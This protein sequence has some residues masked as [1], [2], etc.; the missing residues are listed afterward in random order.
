MQKDYKSFTIVDFATDDA[1]LQHHLNPTRDSQSF[2]ENWLARNPSQVEEWQQAQKLLEAVRLGLEDYTRTFL[3]KEAEEQLLNRILNTNALYSHGSTGSPAIVSATWGKIFAVA[4]CLLIMLSIGANY[5]YGKKT[6]DSRTIYNRHK[7]LLFSSVIEKANTT[8]QVDSIKL[9]DGS[10]VLL[11]PGS[12][13]SYSTEF[14]KTNRTVSIS[15]RT[16]LDVVKNPEK[17]FIV[18]ANE[19]VTRVLG[20]RFEVE[21]YEDSKDVVVKVLSGQVSVFKNGTLTTEHKSE[22]EQAGV[23]LKQNQQV[24]FSRQSEEFN[25]KLVDSPL[26]VIQNTSQAPSFTYEETSVVS[27][28]EDL[29]KAYGIDIIYTKSQLETCQLTASLSNEAFKDK[30]NIICKSI[31]ATYE[32]VD[33]YIII[34]SSGC[35][36]LQS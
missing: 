29:E 4:A 14:G 27:V 36:S 19:L 28:F 5:F 20:T 21:A 24:K 7:A 2:W 30:L 16:M 25:K 15:G 33:A 1:F 6:E 26:P 35:K 34:H 11:Y 10:T 18:Y 31:G 3:S 9:P 13:I 22:A 32:V 12:L 23:V 8:S 17:P